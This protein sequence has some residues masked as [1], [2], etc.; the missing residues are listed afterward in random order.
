MKIPWGT[1]GNVKY[2]KTVLAMRKES[3]RE[4]QKEL[5]HWIDVHTR[6]T[7]IACVFSSHS[8][9]N[10]KA[11][12][13]LEIDSQIRNRSTNWSQW[14]VTNRKKNINGIDVQ[15]ANLPDIPNAAEQGPQTLPLQ[16][17]CACVA[18]DLRLVKP[19]AVQARPW[20]MSSRLGEFTAT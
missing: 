11:F 4:R 16:S 8:P 12:V 1:H 18:G 20:E 19:D 15:Y 17:R 5:R 7:T 3:I 2:Y 13:N 14:R 9:K 10:K 6:S